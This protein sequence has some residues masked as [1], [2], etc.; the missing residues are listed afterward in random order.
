MVQEARNILENETQ[1]F[2]EG[3]YGIYKNG[4][5]EEDISALPQVRESEEAKRAREGFIYFID[6]KKA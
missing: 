4:S 6:N 2:L 5:V 3:V 1:E